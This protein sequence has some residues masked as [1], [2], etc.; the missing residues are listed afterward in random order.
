M[1][2]GAPLQGLQSADPVDN[3]INFVIVDDPRNPDEDG[4]RPFSGSTNEDLQNEGIGYVSDVFFIADSEV[5][6]EMYV[7]FLNAVASSGDEL[8]LYT[9]KMG[10]EGGILRSWI[11]AENTYR[12]RL[13]NANY[14]AKPVNFVSSFDA[15]RFINW[16]HNGMPGDG[17]R[18]GASIVAGSVSTI[19]V[20]S[21]GQGYSP[22]PKVEISGGGGSGVA[23]YASSAINAT[24]SAANDTLTS[25]GPN[26]FVDGDKVRIVT[27]S[28]GAGLATSVD[29]YVRN[30]SGLTFQLAATENVS[31]PVIDFL[32]DV[33]S[34]S[35]TS[36][37][38]SVQRIVVTSAGSGYT[39]APSVALVS[40]NSQV[41]ETTEAGAYGLF[42]RNPT[43]VVRR[44]RVARYFLPDIDE[45]H[46]AAYFD[47]QPG[48]DL[49]APFFWPRANQSMTDPSGNF[50]PALSDVKISAGPSHYGTYDQDG[51]V[52]EWTDSLLTGSTRSIAGSDFGDAVGNPRAY[53]V[54]QSS[55]QETADVGFRVAKPDGAKANRD[56]TPVMVEV[57]DEGNE[58]DDTELLGDVDYPFFMMPQEVTNEDYAEFLNDVAYT[59]DTYNLYDT[60][61]SIERSFADDGSGSRSYRAFA[62]H[63]R[64][65]VVFVDLWSAMRYCNW[66]HNG[67][68]KDADTESGAY[69]L[70]GNVGPE[71]EKVK[72]N[73]SALYFLPNENEWF[74]AAFY[75]PENRTYARYA[76]RSNTADPGAINFN[77]DRSRLVDELIA[78]SFYDTLAQSGNVAEWTETL[79]GATTINNEQLRKV[80]GGHYGSSAP[81]VSASGRSDMRGS[82]RSSFVGFRVAAYPEASP[83]GLDVDGDEMSD[84]WERFY[85]LLLVPPVTDL[86]PGDDPDGD[87]LT[88]LEEFQIGTRPTGTTAADSDGDTMK[89]G[90]EV[91][92]GLDPRI[93]SDA[94]LDADGDTLTNAEEF[95]YRT[96]PTKA[97]TDADKMR[98]DWEVLYSLNATADDSRQD[99]DNDGLINLREF[100][101][102]TNPRKQDTDDD[103]LVD[104][105][106]VD[107]HATDPLD[108]DTDSD[109]L[110]DATEV[111][112][113]KN[114]LLFDTVAAAPPLVTVR[115]ANNAGDSAH[116]GLGAVERD[117]RI[118][119]Y[120]VTNEDYIK[121]L[122]AAAKS[123]SPAGLYDQRMGYFDQADGSDPR[124]NIKVTG[125]ILRSGTSG[126]Y[127]YSLRP[128]YA[129]KPVNF[130]SYEAALRYCNWLH[131]GAPASGG[132]ETGAYDMSG[133]K[134]RNTSARFW[135]PN[136]DEWY[137]AAAYDL[138]AGSYYWDYACQTDNPTALPPQVALWAY[139]GLTDV[140]K[141]ADT[142]GTY[143]AP[144]SYFGTFGQSGN[145]AEW[146]ERT[147]TTVATLRGGSIM[148]TAYADLTGGATTR[149]S[150]QPPTDATGR[151]DAGFRIAS[152]APAPVVIPKTFAARYPGLA[153]T[154]K[155]DGSSAIVD[156]LLG[157]TA[158]TPPAKQ[159]HPAHWIVGGKMQY[160]FAVRI[161]DPSVTYEVQTAT[162]L[163][164]PWTTNNVTALPQTFVSSELNRRTFEVPITGDRQRFFR[165]WVR[166]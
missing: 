130:V 60:R 47:P 117:Y 49:P 81:A 64:K 21:R 31:A 127:S 72:R 68:F 25:D 66:L 129:R 84:T 126:S 140:D 69:R 34:A 30:K 132:T 153:P 2:L 157:G 136:K 137:K 138:D 6:N 104:G 53:K 27:L 162:D 102:G 154:D 61:M 41:A 26:L 20:Q 147:D 39:S 88:N 94:P 19:N 67:G 107:T 56:T 92:Y 37:D 112:E 3:F 116:A 145:A 110:S 55:L 108:K 36:T 43:N 101:L 54:P 12:Y 95:L 5:T 46:K 70:L 115:A 32:T 118:G 114:P 63:K 159:N 152:V 1:F 23:A 106:E 28:G 80:R 98:D 14:A 161:D 139:G 89:D 45:W 113:G 111:N 97:D 38:G 22:M 163:N 135:L 91:R 52:A 40:R 141:V 10:T 74:K 7:R 151:F 76:T 48:D 148:S 16:L 8:G 90:W 122:Q 121:F 17:A 143:D 93:A 166:P 86:Q 44:E 24:G 125:G 120:E 103:E 78:P 133:S 50:S 13:R 142:R 51:N 165:L 155:I 109:G 11:Q 156:Y 124:G 158:S 42:N 15:M 99:P 77:S 82:H 149:S 96:D 71:V 128:G 150:L 79:S 144:P 100:R 18:A 83:L 75:N 134:T 33:A 123:N 131:N 85:G 164:G 58:P 29:Y 105:A 73:I 59:R 87:D 57:G 119:T 65:P 62:E 146:V 9:T 160:S 35:V 4:Y